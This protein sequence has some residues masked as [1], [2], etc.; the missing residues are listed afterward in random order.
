MTYIV[1]NR[2]PGPAHFLQ[3]G[4]SHMALAAET[5]FRTGFFILSSHLFMAPGTGIMVRLHDGIFVC[6][7][8]WFFRKL[9]DI[10]LLFPQPG[11][12]FLENVAYRAVLL[13]TLIK[14]GSMAVVVECYRG[15]V[16]IRGRSLM[17]DNEWKDG[18]VSS[19][20]ILD[21]VA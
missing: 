20:G 7:V 17:C 1:E 4:F 19:A 3:I 8:E 9:K 12:G 11:I 13:V 6:S 16:Q 10:N 18:A 2:L 5:Y 21:I 15:S 14:S